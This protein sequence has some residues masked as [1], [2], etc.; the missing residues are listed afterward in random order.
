MNWIEVL[1]AIGMFALL[2]IVF[3]LMQ[4]INSTLSLIDKLN[5]N[6]NTAPQESRKM[7]SI[8]ENLGLEAPL[9]YIAGKVSGLHYQEVVEKFKKRENEL[10]AKGYNVFNPCE[11][12]DESC[13][14][15][16]AMKICLAHLPYC[17]YIDLLPD[18]QASKGATFE[19]ECA[20]KM[21]IPIYKDQPDANPV[22]EMLKNDF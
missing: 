11:F 7:R 21:G 19:R 1:Q 9:V 6:T 16:E 10:L 2:W 4:L 18:W 13:D 20:L 12:V 3:A 5:M 17:D 8:Q 14:W 15:Q 22:A